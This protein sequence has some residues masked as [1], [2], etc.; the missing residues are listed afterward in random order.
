[1]SSRNARREGFTLIEVLVSVVILATGIVV[2]LEGMQVAFSAMAG[3]RDATQFT[4]L[5][6]SLLQETEAAILSG[7]DDNLSRTGWFDPPSDTI[8]WRRSV[9]AVAPD[10]AG[11]AWLNFSESGELLS[12]QVLV[13]SDRTSRDV[14]L[15]SLVWRAPEEGALEE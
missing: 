3:A 5:A 13:G 12:L 4:L 2:I 14:S 8:W 9:E 10:V 1:M 11:D 6:Q 15:T 7:K